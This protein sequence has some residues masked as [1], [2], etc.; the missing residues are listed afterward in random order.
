MKL[1]PT[2]KKETLYILLGETIMT[3]LLLAV[4]LILDRLTVHVLLGALAGGILAV[5]NFFVMGLTI[6]KALSMPDEDHAKLMRA[7]Q[8][9]R[10]MLIALTVILCLAVAKLDVIATLAPL[11][12]PRIVI[13][14][15]GIMMA[16]DNNKNN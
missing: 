15:R 5:L 10:L 6:Q 9:L 16:K 1:D 8:S 12:F 2:V 7:S 14:V 4:Y 13:F 11:L 3:I